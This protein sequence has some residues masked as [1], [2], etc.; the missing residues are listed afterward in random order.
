MASLLFGGGSLTDSSS[1]SATDPTASSRPNNPTAPWAPLSTA[2]QPSALVKQVLAGHRFIDPSSAQLDVLGGDVTAN[3]NYKD[4]FS[5][6]QGLAALNGLATQAQGATVG[7]TE[8]K[9]LQ[10]AFA[11]GLKQ[12]QTFL[13]SNPFT[14]FQVFQ[15]QVMTSDSTTA[16]VAHETDTFTTGTIYAGPTNAPAPVFQGPVAFDLTVTKVSG[17]QTTVNFDLSEMGATPRTVASVV[18]YLNS[19]LQA[20]G[21]STRFASQMTPGQ[22]QLIQA[23]KTTVTGAVGPNQYAL[24][25]NG[26]S[27]EQLSFSAPASDPAVYVAQTSGL[28]TGKTPDA[29]Q[30]LVKFDASATPIATPSASGQVFKQTLANT[31]AVR[32]LAT[33]ADG[34]VYAISDV[35]GKVDGQ[36]IKGS[37]DVALTKYDS[38]GNVVFTRTLGAASS[39]SGYALAISQDGSQVAVTGTTTTN[40]DPAAVLTPAGNTA[41]NGADAFVTV[42]DAQGQE[43]WTQQTGSPTGGDVQANAVTFGPN[44]MVYV[45]GQTTGPL[46]GT[47]SAGGTDGF[48]QA[49]H[50]VGVPLNDGTNQN[51]W[52]VTPSYVTQ[53]GTTGTDR[54]TGLAVS[55]STVYISSLENGHAVVRS[56]DQSGTGSTSLT[57]AATRDLGDIQ[58]GTVAGVAV[59]ADGSIIVAGS[60]HNGALSVG[61]TTQAYSGGKAVFVASLAADLQPAG[62]DR[63]TYAG[64]GADQTVTA[65]TVSG[66]Q[67]YVAGQITTTPPAGTGQTTAHDGFASAIDPQT[68]VVGW[69]QRYVGLDHEAAPAAIAVSQGGASVLDM[70]GLPNGAIDY[71]ASQQVTA[72]T[73]I[74]PGDEFFVKSGSGPALAVKISADDTYAT[75]AQKIQRASGFNLKATVVAGVKGAGDQISL[76]TTFANGQ[77]SILAGPTGADALQV[78]G[79]KEGVVS[80]SAANKALLPAKPLP[81]PGQA[82]K[83]TNSLRNGYSLQLPSDLGLSSAADIKR[84]LTSLATAMSGIRSIY[85]DLTT[86]PPDPTKAAGS[87][88]VPK[89]LTDQI[90]NYQAA[91]SRLTGGQ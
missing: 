90:S 53:F 75:L 78:L 46:V 55:G 21:I 43:Q 14:G 69:S 42:F 16:G 9:Q 44:G 36:A 39:A 50:S 3:Q 40:L 63:L 56:F 32:A 64:G 8:A 76:K 12:V 6:Y 7:P 22:P 67:V 87:G 52:V 25:I 41:S 29:V 85:R 66:G 28:T 59:N 54:A 82:T 81:K 84:A 35:T 73:S 37:Q 58:G 88:S 57:P 70:L 23:G 80:A 89:Y 27:A 62:T 74:R 17:S 72:N 24:K 51:Q 47:G 10:Q 45:A 5:L 2:P 65:V 18:A 13:S 91:L 19:K 79:F 1:S 33:A 34:S 86:P 48:L 38:T 60:T 26:S 61:T 11:S 83:P 68:G 31:A 77:V 71:S 30:Q 49:F 15:G 4:L 20:S